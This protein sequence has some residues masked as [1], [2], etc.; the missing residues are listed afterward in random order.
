MIFEKLYQMI[1]P[2]HKACP[3]EY[4]GAND[5]KSMADNN[6]SSFNFREITGGGLPS[7]HSY[8]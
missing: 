3:M 7:I 6:S 2:I 1:F 5:E 8:G 4:Y